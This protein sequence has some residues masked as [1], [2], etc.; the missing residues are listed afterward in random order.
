MFLGF[1]DLVVLQLVAKLTLLSDEL[2]DLA[3]DV[4][5]FGHVSS[6][7]RRWPAKRRISAQDVIAA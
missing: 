5:V 4:F 6:V 2:I 1:V 3:E 7:P